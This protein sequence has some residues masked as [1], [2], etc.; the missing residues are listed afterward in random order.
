MARVTNKEESGPPRLGRA[1]RG[2]CLQVR[3]A[4]STT[5]GDYI[6]GKLWQYATLSACPWHPEGGCGFAQHGTYERVHPANT[7]VARRSGPTA[8]R[9][10]SA[11]PDCLASHRS[12]TLDECELIVRL[13]ESAP[14][15]SAACRDLRPEVQLP[16]ILRFVTCVVRQITNALRAIKGLMPIR[17][18]CQPRLCEVA[19]LLDTP[20]VLMTLRDIA[21]RYLPQLP[22]PLGFN[23][24][25][26]AVHNDIEPSQH[27]VGRDP[28]VAFVESGR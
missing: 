26:D 23:P 3:L 12:G 15:L 19:A 28:P 27:G 16:G 2:W 4:T 25:R 20:S 17:F 10:V 9:T 14:S 8:R 1:D 18:T 6:T 22:T 11:L 5:S 13:I 24:H 21:Q 7:R